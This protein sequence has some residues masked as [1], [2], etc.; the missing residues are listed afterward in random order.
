M[1]AARL[2]LVVAAVFAQPVLVPGQ[3]PGPARA[4][5]QQLVVLRGHVVDEDSGASLARA[6]VSTQ[7]PGVATE[8]NFTDD[9]GIFEVR[10]PAGAGRTLRVAKAGF[11][12][13]TV[14]AVAQ[15][16]VRVQEPPLEIKLVRGGVIA[17]R[18]LDELGKP[19]A[20]A[21]IRARRLDATTERQTARAV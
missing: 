20:N 17:G 15:R 14:S 12:P 21:R 8:L 7:V 6:R 13:A 4:A 18:A 9:R 16:T 2:V 3:Q 5:N 11:V 19:V 1:S 10:V